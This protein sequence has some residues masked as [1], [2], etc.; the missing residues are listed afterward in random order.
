MINFA[1]LGAGFIGKVHANNI[2]NHP[3][4]TL[5]Y[6]YDINLDARRSFMSN[7]VLRL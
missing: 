3:R 6:V 4:S 2:H 7:L 5:R 1:I